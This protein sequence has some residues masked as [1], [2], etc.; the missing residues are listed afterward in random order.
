LGVG[1]PQATVAELLAQ[2][3][4][5]LLEVLENLGLAAVHAEPANTSSR[6]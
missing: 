2:D 1:E 3:V 5:F 6:N 4:V